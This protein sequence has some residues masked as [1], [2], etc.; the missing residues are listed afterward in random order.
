MIEPSAVAILDGDQV[1]GRALETLLQAA[2]Y[3][4]KY[5]TNPAPGELEK[6]IS[7]V[8]VVI[9]PGDYD[10]GE[11]DSLQDLISVTTGLGVPVLKLVTVVEE[12][13]GDLVRLVY[14]PCPIEDLKR[15]I[16]AASL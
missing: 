11:K 8:G 15:E 6:M 9:L 14:W 16:E 4:S 7:D 10:G 12:K 13:T 3:K 5:V 2:N 1:V